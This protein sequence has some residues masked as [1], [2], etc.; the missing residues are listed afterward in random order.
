MS[1]YN[2][3]LSPQGSDTN[4]NAA[5]KIKYDSNYENMIFKTGYINMQH[6][7]LYNQQRNQAL[8]IQDDRLSI[9]STPSSIF[10]S[11]DGYPSSPSPDFPLNLSRNPSPLFTGYHQTPADP[12]PL[13][14]FQQATVIQSPVPVNA[15]AEHNYAFDSPNLSTTAPEGR[16]KFLFPGPGMKSAFPY[17]SGHSTLPESNEIN[18]LPMHDWFRNAVRPEIAEKIQ[19]AHVKIGSKS[20]QQKDQY[21]TMRYTELPTDLEYNPNKSRLRKVYESPTVAAD[22]ERNNLASRKSRFKKK[23]AQLITNMHLEFDRSEN[24]E[25]YKM[26]NWMAQVIFNLESQCLDS[27][28]T[29][30]Y[31]FDLRRECGFSYGQHDKMYA[32]GSTL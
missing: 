16:S 29:P 6:K 4:S 23:K 18:P 14:Y 8:K 32:A 19:I 20:A 31:L 26:Q 9:T 15:S 21:L 2:F 22:R 25:L 7:Y 11:L 28:L 27:G 30:E 12:P 10:S 17:D 13:Q 1:S 24:I 3:P 5:K